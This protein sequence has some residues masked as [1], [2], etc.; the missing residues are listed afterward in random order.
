[1]IKQIILKLNQLLQ[2]NLFKE[3]PIL[4]KIFYNKVKKTYYSYSISPLAIKKILYKNYD[5]NYLN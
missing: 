2:R 4:I 3:F 5:N 1:M